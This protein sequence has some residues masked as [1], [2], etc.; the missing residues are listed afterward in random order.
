M[1]RPK[2]KDELM[3]ASNEQYKKLLDLIDSMSEEVRANNFKFEDRDR[4]VRDVLIHLYEWHLLLIKWITSNL[5]EENAKFLPGEYTWKSYGKLNVEFWEK[6]QKTSLE[7]AFSLLSK[8]HSEVMELI[9]TLSNEELFTK[10]YYN[11]TG[12]TSVGSYCVSS[13]SSHYS[14]QW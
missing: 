6:H 9:D 7:E 5:H 4:N 2:S 13:T 11:W 12:T 3:K 10:K 14:I 8:K 1:S